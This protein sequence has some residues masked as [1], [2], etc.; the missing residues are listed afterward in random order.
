MVA[1]AG[2][3]WTA[4]VVL[5][6]AFTTAMLGTTLPTPLYPEYQRVLGFGELVTTLVFATYAVGVIAALL[7]TGRWS[8]ELGRRPMLQ[9]GLALSGASA[10]VFLFAGTTGWLFAGRILSGFSAGIFAGTATA[11]VV[12]VAPDKARAGLVAAAANMGGLGLGPLVA[13]VLGQYA[14]APLRLPYAVDLGLVVLAS[15]GVALVPEPVERAPRPR[16]ALQRITV[17]AGVRAT[18]ARAAIAGFAGFAVLGLFT[19]VSPAFLSTVLHD[20]NR[21]LTGV[22]VLSVFAASTAGQ[23]TSARLTERR[24]M[25]LGCAGLIAGMVLIGASLP[26][27]SL[28]ALL[29]GAVI[30]G[31]GQGMGFRAG[32]IAL[33]SAA[34]ARQRGELT[35]TYFFVLYIGITLPVVGVGA[36][37]TAFGL[38][39]SGVVFAAGVA[40]LAAVALALL[41]RSRAASVPAEGGRSAGGAR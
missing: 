18:F 37:A 20:T 34:P 23:V 26:L 32:L 38:I 5:A 29:G 10:L 1:I 40:A 25:I 39:I 21:A 13:G 15:I 12:D 41:S 17:P 22:V 28:A 4:V 36:A 7:L 27:A 31:F 35:S 6:A 16:L 33:T 11:A 14:P 9:A 24:A 3:G 30:A 19:G 8:D 2:R